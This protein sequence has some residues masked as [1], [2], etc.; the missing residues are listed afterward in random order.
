M[1]T[2]QLTRSALIL[3][4]AA[5]CGSAE[6]ESPSTTGGRGGIGV[7]GGRAG[8]GGAE[9][10]RTTGGSSATTGGGSSLGGAAVSG[11]SASTTVGGTSSSGGASASS[12]GGSGGLAIVLG[13]SG[14]SAGGGALG[15]TTTTGGSGTISPPSGG[16]SP[17][18]GT[19]GVGGSIPVRAD[20][21]VV[22]AKMSLATDGQ[23]VNATIKYWVTGSPVSARDLIIRIWTGRDDPTATTFDYYLDESKAIRASRPDYPSIAYDPYSL[24]LIPGRSSEACS[25]IDIYTADRFPGSLWPVTFDAQYA[26]HVTYNQILTQDLANDWSAVGLNGTD[27]LATDHIGVYYRTPTGGFQLVYG[28]EPTGAP[29]C[30]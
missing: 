30:R 13:G 19:T 17:A 5:G 1:I 27:L 20:Q 3:S 23:L 22:Q 16:A 11:G 29:W 24:F 18:G 8:T 25:H 28:K 10:S 7:S 21:I 4:L 2:R 6:S 12:G 14:G 26:E 15:G 9:L